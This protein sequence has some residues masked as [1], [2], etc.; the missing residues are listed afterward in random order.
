MP[1]TRLR[2][3]A[4][5]ALLAAT[6]VLTMSGA[7]GCLSETASAATPPVRVVAGTTSLTGIACSGGDCVAVGDSAT[8]GVVVPAPGGLPAS[9]VLIPGHVAGL[10]LA[11]VACGS[12]GHCLAV[13]STGSHTGYVVPIDDGGPGTPVLVHAAFALTGVACPTARLCIA[14]GSANSPLV[15]AVAI[16]VAGGVSTAVP[17]PVQIPSGSPGQ[18]GGQTSYSAVACAD[19]RTCY[20]VTNGG[21]GAGAV[22]PIVGGVAG[23]AVPY[24][25]GE[26]AIA[27]PTATVCYAVGTAL[28]AI[29]GG[30]PSPTTTPAPYPMNAIT[31]SSPTSCAAEGPGGV[32]VPLVDGTFGRSQA[33]PGVILTRAISCRSATACYA[34]GDG[35]A[36][37]LF[38]SLAPPSA[39]APADRPVAP[40]AAATFR[41]AVSGSP[42]P[43]VQWQVSTGGGR[44]FTDLPGRTQDT[45]TVPTARL[46]D[47]GNRYR[48]VVTNAAGAAV[49]AAATLTV[50]KAA[51]ATS[52]VA[53]REH[54]TQGDAVR[55]TA[56]VVAASG[57]GKPSGSVEFYDGGRRLG[58]TALTGDPVA[59]F[60][61]MALTVGTH[62]LTARY[63]GDS[64]FAPAGSRTAV[65]VAV[66]AAPTP[67][68]APSTANRSPSTAGL[69][70]TGPR[71]AALLGLAAVLVLTG[72]LALLLGRP[73]RRVGNR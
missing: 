63:T 15:V 59:A 53:S 33:V 50:R 7:I 22:A 47:S 37:G 40:G 58:S 46:R 72:A 44:R 39:T 38:I 54:V 12:A 41:V 71:S 43:D 9:P 14:T 6:L 20:A 25:G 52:L 4:R 30:R 28:R 27:C 48:A 26:N 3:T 60:D 18:G 36:T 62:Q 56:T 31:C 5:H 1:A 67:L 70:N 34:V 45:Y 17:G 16:T 23:R 19:A 73:R 32:G 29:V 69:A 55:L 49:T 68:P 8:G 13:A 21:T 61:V 51:A 42:D 57:T 10:Q 35:T 2:A 11:G 24:T 66:S 64:S 65:T